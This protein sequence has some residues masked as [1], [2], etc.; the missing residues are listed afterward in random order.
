[1]AQSAGRVSA[2]SEATFKSVRRKVLENDSLRAFRHRRSDVAL[3]WLEPRGATMPVALESEAYID[4]L[5]PHIVEVEAGLIPLD[6]PVTIELADEV[7]GEQTTRPLRRSCRRH[8]DGHAACGAH[9]K[10]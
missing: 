6:S 4:R 3:P 8:H 9:P 5:W 10:P 2:A 7:R 1:M